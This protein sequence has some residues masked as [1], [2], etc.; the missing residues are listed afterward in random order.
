MALKKEIEDI[1][2]Y[3]ECNCSGQVMDFIDSLREYATEFGYLSEK[4]IEALKKIHFY[5]VKKDKPPTPSEPK[6]TKEQI[7]KEK[8]KKLSGQYKK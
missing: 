6:L 7:L 4:Q 2:S 8:Y 3:C 5:Q 1:L